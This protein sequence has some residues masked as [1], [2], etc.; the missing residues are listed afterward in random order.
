MS[1]AQ[2]KA[3]AAFV[4]EVIPGAPRPRC[5]TLYISSRQICADEKEI[6]AGVKVLM[7]GTTTG[8][9]KRKRPAG[10]HPAGNWNW[11]KPAWGSIVVVVVMTADDQ[12]AAMMVLPLSML[13]AIAVDDHVSAVMVPVPISIAVSVMVSIADTNRYLAFFRDH[14]GLFA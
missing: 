6:L 14:Q 10:D 4:A 12:N 11:L 7:S 2:A 5:D 8:L 3:H 13:L 9:C 1:G